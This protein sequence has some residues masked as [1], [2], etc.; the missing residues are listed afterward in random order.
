MELSFL[1]AEGFSAVYWA[2]FSAFKKALKS[3]RIPIKKDEHD[4]KKLWTE[5]L[6]LII[7]RIRAYAYCRLRLSEEFVSPYNANSLSP[8]TPLVPR[9]KSFTEGV[10]LM[11]AASQELG[12]N[13][14]HPLFNA[15][16]FN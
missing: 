3:L 5:L 14:K 10:D 13:K 15:Y 1:R 7:I 9:L 4:C 8:M 11:L 2:S 12:Y 6:P 16:F